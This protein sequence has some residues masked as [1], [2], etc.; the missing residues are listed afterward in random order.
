MIW[1]LELNPCRLQFC[2]NLTALWKRR[3][4]RAFPSREW[5]RTRVER[6]QGSVLEV[7]KKM[8]ILLHPHSIF[9]SFRKCPG[10]IL[11]NPFMAPGLM[12]SALAIKSYSSTLSKKQETIKI[13]FMLFSSDIQTSAYSEGRAVVC[14]HGLNQCLSCYFCY[15]YSQFSE[16][17]HTKKNPRKPKYITKCENINSAHWSKTYGGV[18]EKN[19]E[20]RK[21]GN[22]LGYS[23]YHNTEQWQDRHMFIVMRRC[24][25]FR[26]WTG[27]WSG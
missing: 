26:C 19:K 12:R 27:E 3:E 15:I 11:M 24:T 25:S 22:I 21:N 8:E 20:G 23:S 6:K 9:W 10:K 5:E 16:V 1:N 13:W 14:L 4:K 2:W 7:T 18:S 17:S